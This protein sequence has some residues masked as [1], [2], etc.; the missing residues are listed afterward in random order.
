MEPLFVVSAPFKLCAFKSLLT[1]DLGW[2]VAHPFIA[3]LIET[4]LLSP[5]YLFILKFSLLCVLFKL[6]YLTHIMLLP[7]SCAIC[8]FDNIS[9]YVGVY[10]VR[11]LLPF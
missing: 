7:C 6:R 3:E 11:L 4:Y 10:C 8:L 9:I 5:V 1:L 2:A